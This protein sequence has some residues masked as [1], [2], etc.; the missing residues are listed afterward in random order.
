M[1]ELD[2]VYDSYDSTNRQYSKEE[3][4]EYKKQEKQEIYSLIDSTAEKIVT[5][6]KEFQKYL[7]TQA[8]LII[9]L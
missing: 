6:G 8:N 3:Y 7:D 4:A 5:N 2:E 9:I 1:S